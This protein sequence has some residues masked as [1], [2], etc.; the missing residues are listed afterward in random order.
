[1]QN[2]PSPNAIGRGSR[3]RFCKV[4]RER[5]QH[6]S[7]K[8]PPQMNDR[9]NVHGFAHVAPHLA[10]GEDVALKEL[11]GREKLLD[12]VLRDEGNNAICV[13]LQ[14]HTDPLNISYTCRLVKR[15][16]KAEDCPGQQNGRDDAW[17]CVLLYTDAGSST[18]VESRTSADR[19][20]SGRVYR[21]CISRGASPTTAA[22]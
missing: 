21:D 8:R 4:S 22:H 7:E 11:D 16:G 13:G 12:L 20:E 3:T 9:G 5:C 10:L 6:S 1:M 19:G 2:L 18:Y 15:N 17:P 14:L